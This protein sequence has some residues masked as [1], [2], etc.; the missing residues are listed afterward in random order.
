ITKER[1][2]RAA[3]KTR[4][5]LIE[6]SISEKEKEIKEIESKLDL[7]GKDENIKQLKAEI[8]TLKNQDLGF[9]I[10]ETTPIWED[11]NFEAE[12]FDSSQTLFDAGKL[13]EDDIKALLTTW[14]TYDGI[15]LT[16]ELESVDL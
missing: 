16:Q 6:K 2:L 12:Q 15:T 8:R 10:F 3:K 14:K 9:K 7:E 4:K 1:L 5:E 13:T 11:Y